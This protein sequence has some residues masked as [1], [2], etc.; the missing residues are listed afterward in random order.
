MLK[1]YISILIWFDEPTDDIVVS[2]SCII[3]NEKV[4]EILSVMV[5]I[6]VSFSFLFTEPIVDVE[7]YFLTH[8]NNLHAFSKRLFC[9]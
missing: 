5:I 8:W 2:A 3:T 4:Y 1:I 7:G 9:Y 6:L